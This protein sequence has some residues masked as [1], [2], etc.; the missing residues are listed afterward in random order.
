M[1]VA[2]GRR[3]TRDGVL[4][5]GVHLS[6]YPAK[7]VAR[8]YHLYAQ[9]TAGVDAPSP[10]D[11]GVHRRTV[12]PGTLLMR[13]ALAADRCRQGHRRCLRLAQGWNYLAQR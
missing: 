5:E 3:T 8:G 7:L 10:A 4:T 11:G 13:T 6:G 12:G 1:S 2:N 9:G